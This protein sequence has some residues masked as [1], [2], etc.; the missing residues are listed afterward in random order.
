MA[1]ITLAKEQKV[2]VKAE[3]HQGGQERFFRLA[4]R[5]PTERRA[6][7]NATKELDNTME[8][9][10]PAGTAWYDFHTNEHFSGGQTVKKNCPL[11][12]LPIYVRE[13]SIVPMG[14]A[15]HYVTER[16]DAP[17]EIRVY[18]GADAKFTL[19]E[20]DGET[21]DY[22]KGQRATY[23]LVWHDAARTLNIGAR[24]GSFP[25]MRAE[26][27]LTVQLVGQNNR[28]SGGSISPVAQTVSYQGEP[29]EVKFASGSVDH[30]AL[31]PTKP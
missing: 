7:A 26:R 11:D 16:L 17:Y 2:A 18:P 31:S 29:L 22:E 1:K 12:T 8:T 6:L 5:T 23:D 19:Y 25:G 24:Q 3:F 15:V 13:G 28:D 14:P 10:L 27:S 9:Y 30:A 4:W 21:Y 20:D